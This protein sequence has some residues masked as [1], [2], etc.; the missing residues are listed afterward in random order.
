MG[1]RGGRWLVSWG[2]AGRRSVEAT[3][4]GLMTPEKALRAPL[5]LRAL[6]CSRPWRQHAA[7]GRSGGGVAVDVTFAAGSVSVGEGVCATQMKPAI[8]ATVTEKFGPV[9]SKAL[10][11]TG[12]R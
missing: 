6:C 8:E 2:L 11:R 7:G 4:A 1:R 3:S 5:A 10:A 9:V 12:S